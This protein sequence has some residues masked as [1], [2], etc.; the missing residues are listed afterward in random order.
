[1]T[2]D[3]VEVMSWPQFLA[4][5]NP[6]KAGGWKQ[7]E[8][9]T[10][11][12]PTGSGKTVFARNILG[13]R[14]FVT[15]LAN[16]PKDSSMDDLLADGFHK[17]TDWPWS[18]LTP[19][20]VLWPDISEM[21]KQYSQREAFREA[22]HGMYARGRYCI[23]ADELRYLTD[24]LRLQREFSLLWQQ[25]RSSGISV[26]AGIQR[27]RH[28]PLLAYSQATHLFFWR[29]SDMSDVKRISDVG[30]VNT[31]AVKDTVQRLAGSP[32]Q[33]FP[34]AQCCQFLY[35]NTR[36]GRLIVSRVELA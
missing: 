22:L 12:G 33:G 35:A 7:G 31:A 21:N 17:E 28:V 1:M 8:H 26:V 2:T 30:G 16:K 23:Y 15:V 3:R 9:V 4:V 20:V 32:A 27:P 25:G 19:K 34:V 13:L 18:D 36:N 11:I 10:C 6:R 14:R 5:F 29:V 24:D